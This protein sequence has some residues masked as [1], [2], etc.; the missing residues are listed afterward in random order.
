VIRGPADPATQ[1]RPVWKTAD[2]R[3][4]HCLACAELVGW[5]PPP[6]GPIYQDGFWWVS[7]QGGRHA[8]PGLLVVKTRRHCESVGDLTAAEAAALGPVLR[9]ASAALAQATRARRVDIASCGE[10]GRHTRFLLTARAAAIRCGSLPS[11]ASLRVR[12]WLRQWGLLRPAARECAQLVERVRE[13]WPDS[14]P[15]AATIPSGALRWEHEPR[16]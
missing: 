7:H 15:D 3:P 12:P 1:T 4:E 13:A 10:G 2:L 5:A 6:G 9:A 11:A 16:S 8:T 14:G